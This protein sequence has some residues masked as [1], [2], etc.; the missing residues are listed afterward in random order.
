MLMM[1]ELQQCGS[2]W[3]RGNIAPLTSHTLIWTSFMAQLWWQLIMPT[4]KKKIGWAYR[5][6]SKVSRLKILSKLEGL[7]SDSTL[8]IISQVYPLI[9]IIR[10]FRYI[11]YWYAW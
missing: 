11:I 7:G 6:Y 3:T 10:D 1:Q 4:S 2:M 8:S 9:R 5:S